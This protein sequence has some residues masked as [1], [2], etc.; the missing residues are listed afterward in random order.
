[1]I[2]LT[3]DSNGIRTIE[4]LEY[5]DENYGQLAYIILE[6]EL[7]SHVQIHVEVCY[8]PTSLPPSNSTQFLL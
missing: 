5:C 8:L 7:L 1:M 4:R 3:I 6:E 2:R